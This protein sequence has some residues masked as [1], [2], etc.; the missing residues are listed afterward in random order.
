LG[1]AVTNNAAINI[2]VGFPGEWINKW[3]DISAMDH[4]PAMKGNRLY[5][6]NSL[7]KSQGNYT[8]EK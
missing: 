2:Y 4:Y 3:W 6:H 1:G 5:S 8:E 7:D